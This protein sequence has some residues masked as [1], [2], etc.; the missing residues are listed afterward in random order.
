M[1]NNIENDTIEIEKVKFQDKWSFWENYES[2]DKSKVLDYSQLLKDICDFDNIILFYQFWNLYPGREPSKIFT[3]NETTKYFFKEGYRIIAMN[4]FK[5]GIKPEWE[6]DNNK[7]GHIF[8]LDFFVDGTKGKNEFD[9]FFSLAAKNWEKIMLSLIGGTLFNAKYVNGVR[10]VDKCILIKKK[11]QFRFEIWCNN[12]IND[13]EIMESRKNYSET[14]GCPG[15]NIK[16][17]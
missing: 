1:E 5:F 8:N 4:L 3:D 2:R 13:D 14:F 10:F 9:E 6:D 17:I 7:Q 12:K 16:H 15:I 11:F